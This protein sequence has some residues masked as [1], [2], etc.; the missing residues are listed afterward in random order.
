MSA[1][2]SARSR[3]FHIV[4]LGILQI[5][6]PVLLFVSTSHADTPSI[7]RKPITSS[8]LA[9]VGYD[10]RARVLE[11]EFHSGGIYRYLDVPKEIFDALLAA[12]SKGRFFA[13]RIRNQFRF[14]MVKPRSAAT[15]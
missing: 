6:A 12:E 3:V 4:R 7:E 14:Q 8:D 10:E 2:L 13:A 9:S 11:I 1:W 5:I 15:K